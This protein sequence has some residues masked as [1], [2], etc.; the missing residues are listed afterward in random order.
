MNQKSY[1]VKC[2]KKAKHYEGLIYLCKKCSLKRDKEAK[3]E[4]KKIKQREKEIEN[5]IIKEC[6]IDN[7]IRE[8]EKI[9]KQPC[10]ISVNVANE[11]NFLFGR[12]VRRKFKVNPLTKNKKITKLKGEYRDIDNFCKKA[13]KIGFK[14][15]KWSGVEVSLR[16]KDKR[17]NFLSNGIYKDIGRAGPFLR[18]SCGKV[19]DVEYELWNVK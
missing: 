19:A 13:R 14:I 6:K 5:K 4:N 9:L 7:K 2:G 10:M 12:F 1:C 18:M 16:C 15:D 11:G 8:L 3:E 17:Y